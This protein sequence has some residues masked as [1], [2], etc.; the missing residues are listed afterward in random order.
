MGGLLRTRRDHQRAAESLADIDEI[1][2]SRFRGSQHSSCIS[3]GKL[4][5]FRRVI[6]RAKFWAAHG[7]ESG[8]FKTFL[9]QRLVMVS[10]CGFRIERE[11]ELALPVE[12][13]TST[14]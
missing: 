4:L 2:I 8:V 5:C 6:H 3:F 11:L 12:I 14:G 10:T 7:A 9:G 1:D 13:E